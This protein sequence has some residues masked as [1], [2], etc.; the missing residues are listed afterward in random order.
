MDNLLITIGISNHNTSAFVIKSLEALEKLT[1]N[2]YQVIIRDNDSDYKDYLKLKDEL[3][4]TP[5]I[6]LYREDNLGFKENEAS[7]AHGTA[8]NDLISRM[9]T[10]YGAIF[11]SDFIVLCE[12]WDEYLINSINNEYPIIGTQAGEFSTK[13]RDFPYVF[14]FFFLT[15]IMKNLQIDFRPNV[16]E[17]EEVIPSYDTGFQMRDK[18]LNN[19]YKGKLLYL[20]NTRY[21]D[22]KYFPKVICGEYYLKKDEEIFGSHFARGS[23]LGKAKYLRGWKGKIYL[24]P[25]IG[26]YLE[27]AKGKR[28][29]KRWLRSCSKIIDKHLVIN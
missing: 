23:S 21:Y 10:K 5:N 7:L 8:V 28:E 15:E 2:K 9:N 22:S 25:K 19:G 3:K 24:L 17:G 20:K 11:D 1:K 14:G 16:I 26:K 27:R 29:I 6:L 13:E 18:F 12:N 4:D